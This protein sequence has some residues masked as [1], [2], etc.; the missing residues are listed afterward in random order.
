MDMDRTTLS[1]RQAAT[2][3]GCGRS[4]I[5]R[6]LASG[7]L[8]AIRDNKNA[9]QIDAEALDRWADKRP[10]QS[11]DHEPVTEDQIRPDRTTPTDTPETLIRLAVAEA[12]LADVTA[13]RDRLAVMLE[14]ALEPRPIPVSI[15][16]RIFGSS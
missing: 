1:P 4:S 16:S 12:R 7:E 5:M 15:W 8:P 3:A 9:W 10:G 2:R 14:K 6:A 13:E 11:P